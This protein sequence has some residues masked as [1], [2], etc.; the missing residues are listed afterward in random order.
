MRKPLA[1]FFLFLSTIGCMYFAKYEVINFLFEVEMFDTQHYVRILMFP[2]VGVLFGS[3]L[4][5]LNMGGNSINR[6][7][8]HPSFPAF[9]VTLLA[10]YSRS[11]LLFIV[12]VHS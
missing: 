8:I 7:V 10:W 2:L 5:E 1:F 12:L 9:I 4:N 6:I 11:S 3:E